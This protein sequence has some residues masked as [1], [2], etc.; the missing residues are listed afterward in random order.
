MSSFQVILQHIPVMLLVLS[1]ISGVF[2]FA[3]L[4]SSG[5]MPRQ[6]RV[7]LAGAMTVAVYPAVDATH[8]IGM[9]LSIWSLLPLMTQE[10]AIGAVVGLLASIPLLALELSG[11]V[12]GQQL[13]LSIAAVLNPSVDIPGDNLGQLLFVGATLMYIAMGGMELVFGSLVNTFDAM[14]IGTPAAAAVIG[15]DTF[16]VITGLLDSGFDMAMRIAMPVVV[17]IFVE[18]VIVGFIMKTVPSLNILS[19]GF[20]IRIILGVAVLAASITFVATTLHGEL[21]F[22]FRTLHEWSLGGLR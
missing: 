11:V 19:F 15:R 5:A 18:T 3:P 12:M 8:A 10:V 6:V 2:I 9:E 21:E 13:G 17:I 1:R 14:P 22:V 4:L 16:E 20:P 7:Y